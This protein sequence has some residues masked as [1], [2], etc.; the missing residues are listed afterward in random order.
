MMQSSGSICT[1]FCKS[2]IEYF[3]S[4]RRQKI[5]HIWQLAGCWVCLC[6]HCTVCCVSAIVQRCRC[7]VWNVGSLCRQLV[8][9]SILE[10]FLLPSDVKIF[11]ILLEYLFNY[12]I[13]VLPLQCWY[14]SVQCV[15][16]C[17]MFPCHVDVPG[18]LTPAQAGPEERPDPSAVNILSLA[19]K[20]QQQ[21]Y[22]TS[23]LTTVEIPHLPPHN[24]KVCKYSLEWSCSDG[25]SGR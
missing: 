7:V 17:S 6:R 20:Y 3:Y 18:H 8:V 2:C 24:S 11:R 21:R 1:E 22:H 4:C 14:R 9:V 10:V 12:W 13:F 16:C 25:E 5:G 15:S 19:G 23:H